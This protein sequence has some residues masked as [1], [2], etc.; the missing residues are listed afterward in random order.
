S[1][2]IRCLSTAA[3]IFDRF[4]DLLSDS[5][6]ERRGAIEVQGTEG[7]AGIPDS[8]L[9][10]DNLKF[11]VVKE[12]ENNT[13]RRPGAIMV[14]GPPGTGKTTIAQKLAEALDKETRTRSRGARWR[15]LALSPADFAEHGGDRIVARAK[16]IFNDLRRV[17]RC[18]VLLDEMEEFLRV[19]EP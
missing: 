2:L 7:L 9:F 17:R 5:I 3:A 8:R 14:F 1:D 18:V 6:L 16:E 15:F 11:G 4:K 10:R 12:W 13:A 19:R